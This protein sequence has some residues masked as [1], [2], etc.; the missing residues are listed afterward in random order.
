VATQLSVDYLRT[1]DFAMRPMQ[2]LKL[3]AK[4]IRLRQVRQLAG[5]YGA[6]RLPR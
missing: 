3:I 4:N 5:D 2:W 1:Q 6:D